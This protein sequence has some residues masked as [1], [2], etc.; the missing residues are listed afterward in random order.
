MNAAWRFFTAPSDSAF[1]IPS[2]I[3]SIANS[4]KPQ[5]ADSRSSTLK[6][7]VEMTVGGKPGNPKPGFPSFPPTLEIA[8][9]F[10][11]SHNLDHYSYNQSGIQNYSSELLP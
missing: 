6:K 1:S 9:R 11:H 4:A 5:D 7:L 8:P 2:A 3:N 10:P